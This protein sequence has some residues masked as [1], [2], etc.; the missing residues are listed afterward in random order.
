M[1]RSRYSVI[2][3]IIGL[4]FALLL[5]G[6]IDMLHYV[7]SSENRTIVNVRFTLQKMIFQMMA[8]VG[9][10]EITE[11]DFE[12]DFDLSEDRVLSQF[13]EGTEVM[14]SPINNETDFGFDVELHL[15]VDSLNKVLAEDPD[16]PFLPISMEQGY[17]IVLPPMGSDT[18]DSA[19][20]EFAAAFFASSK[21]RLLISKG[22][23]PEIEK[24]ILRS[25]DDTFVPSIKE[26]PEVYLVEF[27]LALWALA[28]A[29]VEI[30][31]Y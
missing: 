16:A 30:Y 13:P 2:L 22:Y 17:R 9:G 6:C 15:D 20:N 3:L 11:K 14:F 18:G 28:E 26:L 4:A 1:R 19:D 29:K 25:G 12:S 8:Q 24:V 27:P 23:I 10:E 5:N 7:G 31:I 21:Y